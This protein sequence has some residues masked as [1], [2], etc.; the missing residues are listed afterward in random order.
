MRCR[1]TLA[2]A[3][4]VWLLAFNSNSCSWGASFATHPFSFYVKNQNTGRAEGQAF[5]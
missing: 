4:C 2:S 3:I 1:N 5:A